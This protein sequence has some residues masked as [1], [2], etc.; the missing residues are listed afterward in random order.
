LCRAINGGNQAGGRLTI[1]R[2]LYFK[3]GPFNKV[4]EQFR[5]ER[6]K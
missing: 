1:E 6:G 2:D 4:I 3:R 5:R